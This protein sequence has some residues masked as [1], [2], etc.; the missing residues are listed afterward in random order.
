M[1]PQQEH[2]WPC[3]ACGSDLAFAPGQAEL[4]CPHCGHRQPIPAAPAA[5]RKR[6]LGELDLDAALA[7]ALPAAQTEAVRL[8]RCPSCGAEIEWDGVTHAR[9]CAFC[10]TPVVA[11]T[12]TTRHIKPQALIPFRITEREG[13]EAM[14]RW[15]GRLWFAPNGLVEYARKGRALTGIY[16]PYWTFDAATRSRYRGERGDAYY[17]TE[18]VTVT[19]D[20]KTRQEQRQVRKIRWSPAQGWVS[21][22]FDDV[23]VLASTALPRRYADALA[24]WDLTALEPYRP[25]YL[26]GFLAEGY[27]VSLADGRTI[28]HEVMAGIIAEDVRRAIGGDEQRIHR[29]DTDHSAETFKHVLLPIWMAAYKYGGKTYRFVVN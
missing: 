23:L 14:V 26:S 9:T 29:I 20:G 4:V 25:D 2:R 16:V 27:T 17:V 13:R 19:R 11:D 8:T 12:G 6:A 7:D 15:L 22:F 5:A 24:P 1:A 10:D 21:R 28:A 3:A 18:T